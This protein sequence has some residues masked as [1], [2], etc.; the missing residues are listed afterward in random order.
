M[1]PLIGRLFD[2]RYVIS[3]LLGRGGMGVVYLARQIDPPRE[4]VIKMISPS[5]RDDP[6]SIARFER[7]AKRLQELHHPN[8]VRFYGYGYEAEHASSYLVME[9]VDGDVLGDV[10]RRKGRLTFEEF[11]PIASQVLKGVGHVHSRNVLIRDIKPSNVML[12]ER[13]GRANFVKLLD[14]GLAKV[15]EGETQITTGHV[16]GTA[17]YIAP[18]VLR[19]EEVDLRSDVYALGVMFYLLLSGRLPF[20]GREQAALFSQTLREEPPQLSTLVGDRSIPG[21]FLDLVHRCLEKDPNR[22]PGDANALIEEMID[23][24]PATL[25]RLPRSQ[26]A[27]SG[28]FPSGPHPMRGS[29]GPLAAAV[30]D[31]TPSGGAVET[32][33]TM[34]S[35]QLHAPVEAASPSSSRI[36]WALVGGVVVAIAAAAGGLAL[37]GRRDVLEVASAAPQEHSLAVAED[38]PDHRSLV[39]AKLREAERAATRGAWEAAIEGYLDVLELDPDHGLAKTGLQRAREHVQVPTPSREGEAPAPVGAAVEAEVADSP[40]EPSRSSVSKRSRRRIPARS[41]APPQSTASAASAPPPQP[42]SAPSPT[43]PVAEPKRGPD[44]LGSPKKTSHGNGLLPLQ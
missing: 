19:G 39:A 5:L 1:N 34:P 44:L 28:N 10:L 2:G 18:E 31:S 6:Q 13:Q 3:Q 43:R 25:F 15:A 23:V 35:A 14:F 22:R 9:Y 26:G 8:I 11:V 32:A 20:T 41:E 30:A 42:A 38:T 40:S 7:E 24:V 33:P 16:L 17:G 12:C 37:L 4:V 29:S 36:G 27:K 21:G